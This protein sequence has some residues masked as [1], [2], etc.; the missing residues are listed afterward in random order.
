MTTTTATYDT[1]AAHRS[2]AGLIRMLA[3]VIAVLMVSLLVIQRS[4][5]AFNATTDNT[6]NQ[7]AA[8]TI[9]LTDNDGGSAMFNVTNS[10]PGVTTTQCL[11][12]SYTGTL[13]PAAA[14]KLYGAYADSAD[15]NATADSALAPYLNL[16]V[17][18][19][20]AGATCGA[21]TGTTIYTGTLAN[22]NTTHTN[23]AGGLSTTWT[24]A[25][26]SETRAFRF[27]VTM[28][29]TNAAMGLNAEPTFTWEVRSA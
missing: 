1:R 13:T 20:N 10:V 29:D 19:G 26:A 5:S 22:F 7:I 6:G 18:T 15:A 23:Y 8:G 28:A 3:V 11:T 16:T 25:T 12:V 24:P 14:I 2:P 17:E 4:E 21:F 9:A 27:T